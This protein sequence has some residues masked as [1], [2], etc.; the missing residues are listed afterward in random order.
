[1]RHNQCKC[2]RN[3]A[4]TKGTLHLNNKQFFRPYL[5]SHCSGVTQISHMALLYSAP[6]PVQVWSNS[7]RKEGK[8][9]LMSKQFLSLFRLVSQRGHS[10]IKYGAPIQ[11]ARTTGVCSKLGSKEGHITLESEKAFCRYLASHCSGVT[12]I[13]HIDLTSNA[14]QPGHFMSEPGNNEVHFTHEAETYF[15]P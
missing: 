2:V 6:D 12:Q 1:M 11:C 7:S 5:A 9:L 4:V 14:P 8:S 13:T 15:R 10:N 3:R